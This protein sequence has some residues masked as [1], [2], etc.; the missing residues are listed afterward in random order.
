MGIPHVVTLYQWLRSKPGVNFP[1]L[2]DHAFA[3]EALD[4]ANTEST[5]NRHLF[6]RNARVRA[7]RSKRK[8]SDVEL[9][10][11]VWFDDNIDYDG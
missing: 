6:L 8:A 2:S 9:E 3:L 7:L 10:E 5:T 1:V 4:E 11:S